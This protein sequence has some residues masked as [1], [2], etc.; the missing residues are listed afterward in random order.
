[1]PGWNLAYAQMRG[2]LVD[3][4]PLSAL[5]PLRLAFSFAGAITIADFFGRADARA[6]FNGVAPEKNLINL[7][8]VLDACCAGAPVVEDLKKKIIECFPALADQ[9]NGA[10]GSA[11]SAPA[12]AP[13]VVPVPDVAPKYLSM[14][15][16]LVN[17]GLAALVPNFVEE[18]VDLDS[19]A[20]QTDEGLKALGVKLGAMPRLRA[21]IKQATAAKTVRATS[22]ST[23]TQP[24]F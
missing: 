11:S 17:L 2:R 23:P 10:G 7:A 24:Q 1:M 4:L 6:L 13:P 15:L 5:D 3:E 12:G 9:I 21:A 16:V 14:A 22:C 18:D 19:A 8:K 20:E